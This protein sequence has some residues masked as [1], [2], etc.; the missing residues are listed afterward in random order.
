[1]TPSSA[2]ATASKYASVA[3]VLVQVTLQFELLCFTR[4][5]I[6]SGAV[7]RCCVQQ[8]ICCHEVRQAC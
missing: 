4:P 7:A 6:S 3:V 5:A 2:S 8:Q 1:M